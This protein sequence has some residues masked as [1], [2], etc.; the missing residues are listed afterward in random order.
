MIIE[1]AG[2]RSVAVGHDQAS[3]RYDWART[4]TATG[5]AGAGQ[6]GPAPVRVLV[7]IRRNLGGMIM[8]AMVGA[9][10]QTGGGSTAYEVCVARAPFDNGAEPSCDSEL[11]GLLIP[12]LPADFAQATLDGLTNGAALP[13]GVLRVDRAGHD[14][15]GSSDEAFG[16]AARVLRAALAATL[17]GG[18]LE[19]GV[20]AA[21]E[22]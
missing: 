2:R 17:A 4:L 15:M 20:R 10:F 7:E 3:A 9:E 8:R 22:G 1:V 11:G 18:D 16:L 14:L 6:A 13:A 12:G 21:Y 5:P 19:S